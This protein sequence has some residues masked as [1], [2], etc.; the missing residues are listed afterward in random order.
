MLILRLGN[1]HNKC[2]LPGLVRAAKGHRV[3]WILDPMHGNTHR[4]AS[5]AKT[6]VITEMQQEI[7]ETAKILNENGQRLAGIHLE[8]TANPVAECVNSLHDVS[9]GQH[10]DASSMI[11][12]P[13]LNP[14]QAERLVDTYAEV[15]L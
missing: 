11:C 2:L 6:R 8:L 14:E 5:G 12:D 4:L 9:N 3:F 13:R 10:F 15:L 1:K 7:S